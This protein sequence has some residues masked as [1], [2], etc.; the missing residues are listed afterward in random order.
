MD[1]IPHME[2]SE[3]IELR[4]L[5]TTPEERDSLIET[6]SDL[7]DYEFVNMVSQDWFEKAESKCFQRDIAYTS[8]RN[9]LQNALGI[10]KAFSKE[11]ENESLTRGELFFEMNKFLVARPDLDLR[12]VN[13]YTLSVILLV[14][15]E[16]AYQDIFSRDFSGRDLS[17]SKICLKRNID[18]LLCSL[19][20]ERIEQII[21]SRG[22]I[23]L[24]FLEKV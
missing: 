21:N 15:A 5:P 11:T 18:K 22:N 1:A 2:L 20:T 9:V 24:T 8:V 19:P 10:Q 12:S 17:D 6:N 3:F 23:N 4:V 13:Y 7:L 14:A 16:I